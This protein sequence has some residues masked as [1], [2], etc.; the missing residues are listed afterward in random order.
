MSANSTTRTGKRMSRPATFDLAARA[1]LGL[2]YLGRMVDDARD[3]EPYSLVYL[4]RD[5]PEAMHHSQD[6]G[7][8]V[9]LYL[10]AF[11]LAR[12]MTG[13]DAHR[14]TESAMRE[15]LLSRLSDEDGLCWRPSTPWSG[16][17]ANMLDQAGALQG[18][19]AWYVEAH[20]P[21]VA[22]RIERMLATLWRLAVR[23]D[24]CCYLPSSRYLTDG[25]DMT[26]PRFGTWLINDST[27][28]AGPLITGILRYY[29]ETRSEIALR[30]A[31]G[32]V[33]FI[34]QRGGAFRMDG[35]WCGPFHNRAMTIVGLI[36]YAKI[37][38]DSDL[39]VWCR[40]M[41]DYALARGTRFGWFPELL[42]PHPEDVSPT[43]ETCAIADMIE[44]AALLAE[45]GETQYWGWVE[46]YTRNHL[47]Q[48][49]LRDVSWVGAVHRAE[50]TEQSTFREVQQR[51]LGGFAGWSL[52][53]DFVGPKQ[54][55]DRLLEQHAELIDATMMSC[56]TTTGLR[57]MYHAWSRAV[58]LRDGVPQVNL[59][60]NRSTP[61][62]EVIDCQPFEG[63]VDILVH[64]A[65]TL[66]IHVPDWARAMH[67]TLSV[68]GVQTRSQWEGSYLRLGGLRPWQTVS[69]QY[70][71]RAMEEQVRVG[72]SQ[73]RVR[74]RGDTVTGMSPAGKVQ[75]LYQRLGRLSRKGLREPRS[76]RPPRVASF[77]L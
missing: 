51:A 22:V 75:P 66:L 29:E 45:S 3:R 55:P 77:S 50:D 39:L 72:E 49:Q 47:A 17:E 42:T 21:E 4:Q 67:V 25:W 6:F 43:C 71:V 38:G 9:G 11:I 61:W 19:V 46:R 35:Q 36:R 26:R 41:Y 37:T 58:V 57:G 31:R 60:M 1:E 59:T 5:P 70:P 27:H 24:D 63:R 30:L 64:D 32:L 52:P 54:Y 18:L 34:T 28:I 15:L 73:Y 74:W 16:P 68:D 56:C 23:M 40:K 20:N 10:E 53:N 69:L 14:D 33:D 13:G 65:P 7:R 48:T 76:P 2:N 44:G 62:I 8:M 12:Q